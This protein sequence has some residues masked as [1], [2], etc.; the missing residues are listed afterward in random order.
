MNSVFF[1]LCLI[2]VGLGLGGGAV[3]YHLAMGKLN[4]YNPYVVYS[5]GY[6]SN[7]VEESE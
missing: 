4:A 3:M 5:R 1:G 2:V 6:A 7:P